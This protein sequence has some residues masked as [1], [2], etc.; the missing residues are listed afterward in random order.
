M[1]KRKQRLSKDCPYCGDT[2][3]TTN[4]R[5]KYCDT[6]CTKYAYNRRQMEKIRKAQE[7]LQRQAAGL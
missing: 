3:K 5:K 7:I 4:P 1:K 2:F 6:N